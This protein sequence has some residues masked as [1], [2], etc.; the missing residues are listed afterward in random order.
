M[1]A[2]KGNS[3]GQQF[4]K[5]NASEM[6]KRKHGKITTRKKVEL[7]LA[8]FA[9]GECPSKEE[10]SKKV[11]QNMIEAIY[12]SDPKI[13]LKATQDFGD[14][15]VAKKREHSGEIGT[16][17]LVSINYDNQDNPSKELENPVSNNENF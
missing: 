11:V 14:Y 3:Y 5:A 4:T 13:R 17:I 10:A 7:I 12:S 2:P 8:T 15:F 1:A 6:G 9:P 16:K